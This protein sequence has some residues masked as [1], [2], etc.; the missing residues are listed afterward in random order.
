MNSLSTQSLL[1]PEPYTPGATARF[2][3]RMEISTAFYSRNP[4]RNGLKF[5]RRQKENDIEKH[6]VR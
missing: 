3:V 6:M 2:S 1:F 5:Y 4:L